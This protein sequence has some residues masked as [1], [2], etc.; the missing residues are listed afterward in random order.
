MA[1]DGVY[2]AA[3]LRGMGLVHRVSLMCMS[4]TG[5]TCF[6][7]LVGTNLELVSKR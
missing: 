4:T 5:R 2:L 1:T 3:M 7:F 6:S